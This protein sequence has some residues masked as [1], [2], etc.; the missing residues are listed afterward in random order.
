MP[1]EG[2]NGTQGHRAPAAREEMLA[3]SDASNQSTEHRLQ[4]TGSAAPAAQLNQ[5]TK[6]PRALPSG[7]STRL[8]FQHLHQIR[9]VTW[10]WEIYTTST[11]VVI[12]TSTTWQK[13][14]PPPPT[15]SILD[16][17][18]HSENTSWPP[19]PLV[20]TPS[21]SHWRLTFTMLAIRTTRQDG[22]GCTK[23]AP[24]LAWPHGKHS[25]TIERA[26]QTYM[27]RNLLRVQ[28]LHPPCRKI[29]PKIACAQ[30]FDLCGLDGKID[31]WERDPSIRAIS[32][33]DSQQAPR[34]TSS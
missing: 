24:N 17:S 3:G 11:M 33:A 23:Y 30:K 32:T 15:A 31:Y 21:S 8:T 10:S 9:A 29:A 27:P 28:P 1:N 2:R 14:T 12:N 16:S 22:K 19:G 5:T 13:K 25:M 26:N 34:K 6:S 4:K 20:S 7:R 18:L